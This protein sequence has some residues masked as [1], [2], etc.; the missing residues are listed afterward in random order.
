MTPL[1]ACISVGAV[2]F[3]MKFLICLRLAAIG[4]FDVAP[5]ASRSPSWVG[6][7]EGV[8]Y[9]ILNITVIFLLMVALARVLIT[10]N[11]SG[12]PFAF[13]RAMG[14][15]A[16]IILLDA[17]V[18]IPL[19]VQIGRFKATSPE[20]RRYRSVT[21]A[22]LIAILGQ[23][24]VHIS[25]VTI[26]TGTSPFAAFSPPRLMIAAIIV[27][28]F[29]LAA[30]TAIHTLLSMQ[31]DTAPRKTKLFLADAFNQSV[32]GVLPICATAW[33]LQA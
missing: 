3:L 20:A 9:T 32:M 5:E 15:A 11:Y 33:F 29:V 24:A 12:G 1:L 8:V 27:A 4:Q 18:A 19:L 31:F 28:G 30:G 17:V 25:L 16:C 14:L 13:D 22:G 26:A 23:G 2:M 7:L 21:F 6:K 10:P